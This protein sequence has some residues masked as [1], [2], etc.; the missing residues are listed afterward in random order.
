MTYDAHRIE[1]VERLRAENASDAEMIA[2]VLA[3]ACIVV[4]FLT[5][6]FGSV[7]VILA[8]PV[9]AVMDA[10]LYAI[11]RARKG[12]ARTGVLAWALY[13]AALHHPAMLACGAVARLAAAVEPKFHFVMLAVVAGTVALWFGGMNGVGIVVDGGRDAVSVSTV[14]A[15]AAAALLEWWALWRRHTLGVVEVGDPVVLAALADEAAAR[16]RAAE[17]EEA[18]AIR[19]MFRS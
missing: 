14:L 5:S 19:R 2:Q 10:G 13:W 4:A 17:L 6:G 15:A 9:V 7:L 11:V 18:E 8:G 16:E 12:R 3:G 1:S